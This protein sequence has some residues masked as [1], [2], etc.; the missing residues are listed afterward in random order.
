MAALSTFM[1]NKIIDHMLRGQAYTVPGTIY[2]A[3]F[4]TDPTEEDTGTEVSGGSYARKA[5][6]LNA[7]SGGITANTSLITFT[8][9]TAS[10]GTITH[11]GIYDAVT[12]GNLLM[13]GALTTSK[14]V[15]S[16]DTFTVPAG[17]LDIT[18]D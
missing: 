13:H 3:L 9:A 14:A 4:T 2:L 6:T 8:T 7:G 5:L 16:G 1:E 15:G 10:W 18:F 12:S 11:F 17:N